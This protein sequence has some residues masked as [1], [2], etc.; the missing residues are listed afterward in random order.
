MNGRHPVTDTIY[1]LSTARGRAGIAVVRVSG[2]Q[3]GVALEALSGR[4]PKPRYARL[5]RLRDPLDGAEIDQALVL[6]FPGPN[7]E[8]GEDMA[9][10][11]LH[12]GPAVIAGALEALGRVP[13][14]R[15]AQAGEFV[16][17]AF[18]NGKL[19]LSAVEGLADLIAAET[20]AQRRQ[21]LKQVAGTL[22]ARVEAWRTRLVRAMAHLEA[23][24]DFADEEVP[25]DLEA[26]VRAEILALQAELAAALEDRGRGE[27]LRSGLNVAIIGPPNAGKSSILNAL[28]RRD[29]AIVSEQA[30]T[31]RDVIEVRLDLGGYPVTLADTAGLRALAADGGQQDIEAEGMRRAARRAAEADLTLAVFD[32]R[33]ARD[34]DPAVLRH[35]TDESLIVLNKIDLGCPA[36]TPRADGIPVLSVSAKTGQGLDA[37]VDRLSAFAAQ[38]LEAPGEAAAMTRARH[39]EAVSAAAEALGRAAS[40]GAPELVAEDLRLAA[41]ALGR[42]TGRVDVEDLLD[43]IFRDFCIGK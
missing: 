15:P 6:W 31:T 36:H 4:L 37:L 1:A 9:E 30:G 43:V 14:L 26:G 38:A 16:R 19:D 7:S 18:D 41:R 20:A 28:A 40:A 13:G 39:R 12:G 5:A 2:A 24:I 22:A 17:R 42:I 10:L 8:T 25:G 11:H 32:V 23:G 21:A 3:A 29:V 27:R 35:L 33:E 34:L